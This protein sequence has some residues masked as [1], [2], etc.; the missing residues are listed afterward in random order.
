MRRDRLRITGLVAALALVLIAAACG[1]HL[2]LP[3]QSPWV[4]GVLS[5]RYR[6]DLTLVK[7]GTM[8]GTD[9]CNRLKGGWKQD[10]EAVSFTAVA[11]TQMRRI[12]VD[13]WSWKADT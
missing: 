5:P 13:T 7:D 10:G 9:G 8:S 11:G 6:P 2:C 12:G 1:T 3:A 4:H